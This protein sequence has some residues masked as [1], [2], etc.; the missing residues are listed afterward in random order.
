MSWAITHS[1]K[2]IWIGPKRMRWQKEANCGASLI[3]VSIL[4]KQLKTSSL[5]SQVRTIQMSICIWIPQ[6]N[7]KFKSD[8][9]FKPIFTHFIFRSAKHICDNGQNERS[10]SEFLDQ[11][12]QLSP[13]ANRSE[14]IGVPGG[15][16][17]NH[18]LYINII[19]LIFL[20]CY[21]SGATANIRWQKSSIYKLHGTRHNDHNHIHTYN[22]SNC[23]NVRHRK[24]RRSSRS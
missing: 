24:E 4:L 10:I 18:M 22:W 20:T 11:I 8:K 3:W 17:L 12:S 9:D 16:K 19:L 13:C 5:Y 1:K 21:R 6:V 7:F 2:S 15:R 23:T 14:F